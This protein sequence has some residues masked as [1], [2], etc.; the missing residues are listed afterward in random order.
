MDDLKK[1][2]VFA[3]YYEKVYRELYYFALHTLK[4]PQDAEDA[5]S[6]TVTDAF[7]AVEKLRDNEK[8]R[9]WIFQCTLSD[10]QSA[11]LLPSDFLPYSVWEGQIDI[12]RIPGHILVKKVDC[13]TSMHGKIQR[14]IYQWHD[15]YKQSHLF[16]IYVIH[17]R[18]TL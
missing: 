15:A 6:E 4:N 16:S 5:V 17:N 13:S 7:A 14:A 12:N 11:C 10:L 8:F 9:V 3:A 1:P 18:S 2:E